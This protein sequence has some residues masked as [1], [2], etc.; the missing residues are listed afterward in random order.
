[1][2][3]RDRDGAFDPRAWYDPELWRRLEPRLRT[4]LANAEQDFMAQLLPKR[5]YAVKYGR[6]QMLREVFEEADE[7]MRNRSGMGEL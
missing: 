1:M 2:S 6:L 7:L 5:A 4:K 3:D